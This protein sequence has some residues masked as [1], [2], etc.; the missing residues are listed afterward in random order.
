MKIFKS[1][2][3]LEPDTQD[4]I[5][6]LRG[7]SVGI[8]HYNCQKYLLETLAS[9]YASK[10]RNTE[11]FVVDDQTPNFDLRTFL[12]TN[13][14][15][16]VNAYVN[17]IN[18]GSFETFNVCIRHAKHELVHILH[19]DDTVEPNFY[20]EVSRIFDESPD[21]E[22]FLC[23]A[24]HID[25]ESCSMKTISPSEP[26]ALPYKLNFLYKNPIKTPAVVVKKSAFAKIGL[27]RIDLPHTAD[28]D[29]W[30]RLVLNCK[31]I[32]LDQTLCN[33]RVFEESRT[34]LQRKQGKA[35][36]GVVKLHY[37]IAYS[38]SLYSP[39]QRFTLSARL[40]ST[41]IVT[42][43][44]QILQFS[45]GEQLRYSFISFSLATIISPI[46]CWPVLPLIWF[47][48]IAKRLYHKHAK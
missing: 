39:S 8:P 29:L 44:S 48:N 27:Y 20:S 18:L 13:G 12:D 7:I 42:L 33:Y 38:Y 10:V 35:W 30:I 43:F 24:K 37:L 17:P 9:V 31:S 3:G 23:A 34:N 28:W 41:S 14:Y 46:F 5:K 22:A 19:A 15:H 6:P 21:I 40:S 4:T 47:Y 36:Y 45:S 2:P 26:L 1:I 25:H 32:Y 16:H 11:I